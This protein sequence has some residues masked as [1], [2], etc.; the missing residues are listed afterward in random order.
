M[1]THKKLFSILA[2]CSLALLTGCTNGGTKKET[3]KLIQLDPEAD[4][5]LID[6][7]T[8]IQITTDPANIQLSDSDFHTSGG[9]IK[10]KKNNAEFSASEVGTYTISA[11]KSGISSNTVTIEVVA[12]ER[13]LASTESDENDDTSTVSQVTDS[14]SD[15]ASSNSTDTASTSQ[16]ASSQSSEATSDAIDVATVLSD[17]QDYVGKTITIIG[18]LPQ[19]AAYDENKN[20]Y[21]VIFPT[22]NNG[23]D[24]NDPSDRLRLDGTSITIGGCI[25]ELTG[26][27]TQQNIGD[28]QYVFDVTSFEEVSDESAQ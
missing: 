14:S 24:I 4:K 1:K 21:G 27:L 22:S 23:G 3:L 13:D 15:T 28:D 26:T 9:T 12:Q 10:I 5:V 11:Q 19:T 2:V 20:P 16:S 18:A 7:N 8:D 25:A 6:T 17:P